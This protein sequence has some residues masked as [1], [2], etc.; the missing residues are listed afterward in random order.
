MSEAFDVDAVEHLEA[1]GL[2]GTLE[3]GLHACVTGGDHTHP[4]QSAVPARP[5]PGPRRCWPRGFDDDCRHSRP[6]PARW[7]RRHCAPGAVDTVQ[8]RHLVGLG[9]LVGVALD[10]VHPSGLTTGEGDGAHAA[11]ALTRG[12]SCRFG[13]GQEAGLAEVCRVCE[14]GGVAFHHTDACAPVVS[15]GDLF[16]RPSSR[17]AD[18][19]RFLFFG[20][21][22]G[23]LGAVSGGRPSTRVSTSWS[24]IGPPYRSTLRPGARPARPTCR[25]D[26][27]HPGDPRRSPTRHPSG[28]PNQ[29]KVAWRVVRRLKRGGTRR[30]EVR[31]AG[32]GTRA[33]AVP[34]RRV[35]GHVAGPR[36]GAPRRLGGVA[37][38]VVPDRRRGSTVAHRDLCGRRGRH[39]RPAATR[40]AS[41][42][43]TAHVDVRRRPGRG[44]GTL[45]LQ[46]SPQRR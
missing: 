32:G 42:R 45:E 26:G 14:A 41:Q 27:R 5:R 44:R 6:T 34:Q 29:L 11:S 16:D 40:R 39:R 21:H 3:T 38:G 36:V 46:L 43:P 13:R 35:P 30:S 19:D 37:G 12:S 18:V 15:A 8:Q 17:P 25:A 24:I 4:H 20:E 28:L 9:H 10:G 7:P 33:H 2:A 22:L 31:A 23:E 1:D